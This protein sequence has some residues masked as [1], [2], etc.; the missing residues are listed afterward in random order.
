MMPFRA[1]YPPS[2]RR[3]KSEFQLNRRR[4]ILMG[5]AVSAGIAF[6]FGSVFLIYIF[7]TLPRIDRLADYNPP[8]VTQVL[9]DDGSLV[10]EFYLERR[11]VV[12]V[13]KIPAKLI[14][15]FVAAE[16]ANFY[17]HKGLDYLGIVRAALKNVIHFSRREGASTITQQ[18]ARSMLL[19][20]EKTFTRKVRE[21][22]LATRMEK[23]LTKDEILYIYL[24]QI[25][26]GAGA[27]GVQVASES[28]FGKSVDQLNLAEM[29]LLAG[30]P[31][32]PNNYNPIKHLERARERQNYVLNRMVEVGFISPAEA[33]HA[34]Q[35]PIEIRSL[36]K[37][38]S[39]QS[40]YFLEH[41]RIQLEAKYG[42]DLLY[43]GG[44]KIWTT[45]NAEMQRAAFDSIV[46]GLKEV[47]KRQG[48]RGPLR[49]LAEK[50]VDDFSR[51]VEDGI[52]T[53][54][55]TPGETYMGIVV[56]MNTAKGDLTVRVGDRSGTLSRKNR[57][58]A[59]KLT[60]V[61]AYGP[62]EKDKSLGLGAVIEVTV[63][64]ADT[65]KV[66]A[67][68]QLDQEPETQAALIALDPLTGAIKA[69]VGG[70]N[71]R[72][73][74]FNRA[75]QARRNAGSAFKPL[76]YAAAIDKGMTPAT[77]IDDSQEDYESGDEQAW[78]P[79]NYDNI[80]RGPVTMREALTNSINVVSVKILSQIGVA[81]AIEYAQKLGIT[82]PLNANLTLALGSS[83][84][85]PLELTTAYAT[86]ANGGNRIT[87]YSVTKV[88]DGSGKI[89]EETPPPPPVP[90]IS[91]E[92][93]YVM[94]NLMESVVSSGTGQRAKSLG[95]PVAGKTGTTNDIKDAWFIAYVPQLLAGVW[96]G[97]DQERS[98]GAGGSGGQAAA[99]IW[100]S[101]MQRSLATMPVQEFIPPDK[102]VFA[103]IN[104]RSGL[105]AKD[106]TPGAVRECFIA[107]TQ[108]TIFDGEQAKPAE[109]PPA[110]IP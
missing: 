9:G 75:V 89:L 48:F 57:D 92:T 41:L 36:K 10:G 24:N 105:L 17:Q 30:L 85:T 39:E 80:Y 86:F 34:R 20:R 70:Y 26:L 60:L 66:G 58:W 91:P 99:P 31:K 56:G 82:S 23:R 27:Y 22:I 65:N 40:A 103:A 102:V 6:L 101:F 50:D 106:G 87:P 63:Q 83:S 5:L 108:P 109:E 96:V 18:V 52:D 78:R 54:T 2:F 11:T 38:N 95:R 46:S 97:Y 33:E 19:T 88:A 44:M 29:A 12:P 74:Q 53:L 79:K 15:A 107:G 104:P 43:K 84:V 61:N 28:Y 98:L 7:A 94:T 4:V 14:Q 90:V 100:T 110:S 32:S 69:M 55:L 21:A 67:I 13:E 25:Y 16:D 8:I 71:F 81:Y 3:L 47:D 72:K 37:V 62:P 77:I 42:E 45:M 93:A 73:S 64:G 35:T 51:K 1:P 68:F 49:Y 59:G 76:I